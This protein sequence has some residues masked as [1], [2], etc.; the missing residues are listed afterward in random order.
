MQLIHQDNPWVYRR[1]CHITH[2]DVDKAIL[3]KAITKCEDIKVLLAL[4]TRI[5]Q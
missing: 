4:S 1:I 2:A 5:P 3:D